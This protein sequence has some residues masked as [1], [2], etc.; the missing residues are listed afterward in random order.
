MCVCFCFPHQQVGSLSR[1]CSFRK[2]TAFG[3]LSDQAFGKANTTSMK[4]Q[5]II[6]PL[7]RLK[8]L[9]QLIPILVGK[10]T[11]AK[12]FLDMYAVYFTCFHRFVTVT[13]VIQ[14]FLCGSIGPSLVRR[15][16]LVQKAVSQVQSDKG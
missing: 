5:F 10:D 16:I 13:K 6:Q 9:L 2:V 4:S 14:G 11:D 1:N 3:L 12:L 7:N 15:S 8:F